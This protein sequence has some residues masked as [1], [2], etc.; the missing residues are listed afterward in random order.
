MRYR[1]MTLHYELEHADQETFSDAEDRVYGFA[2]QADDKLGLL[3]ILREPLEDRSERN[4]HF[5]MWILLPI[6]IAS[7]SNL[8]DEEMMYFPEVDS[9][10]R[11]ASDIPYPRR[12]SGPFTIQI[13]GYPEGQPNLR[14]SRVTWVHVVWL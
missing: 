3:R 5:L 9:I 1:R 11:I 2:C 10:V 4:R 7:D 8:E 14:Q 12:G 13:R 6:Y